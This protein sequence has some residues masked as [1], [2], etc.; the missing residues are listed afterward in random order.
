MTDVDTSI[1]LP[2]TNKIKCLRELNYPSNAN[3]QN[4]KSNT[5]MYLNIRKNQYLLKNRRSRSNC[6]DSISNSKISD[7]SKNNGK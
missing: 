4:E 1:K 6:N 2:K 5:K 3:Y 7:F